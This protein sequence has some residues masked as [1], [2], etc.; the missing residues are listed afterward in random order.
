MNAGLMV[1]LQ[2]VQSGIASLSAFLSPSEHSIAQLVELPHLI[3][4]LLVVRSEAFC[5]HAT[6]LFHACHPHS[7]DTSHR[8]AAYIA[9]ACY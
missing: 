2:A 5:L 4:L 7:A 9:T 1:N 8:S 3:L 6:M